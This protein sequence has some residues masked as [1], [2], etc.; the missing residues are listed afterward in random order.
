MVLSRRSAGDRIP[1]IWI[2]GHGVPAVVVHPDGAQAARR[3]PA[4]AELL[5]AKR[6]VLLIDTF[7]TGSAVAPRDRSYAIF[8]GFNQS[9]DA[10]RVQDILTALAFV[11]QKFSGPIDLVGLGK[12]GVWS[13]FA[14][15]VAPI[16]VKL[17]VDAGWFHGSDDE[18][19]KDFNVPGIQRAGGLGA[20]DRLTASLH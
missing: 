6:P 19:L 16:P 9:D 14:A 18:F 2:E 13:E 15:A 8:L 12:A 10:C 11:H 20:A 4:V 5:K 17:H 7:Q 3:D 1:G